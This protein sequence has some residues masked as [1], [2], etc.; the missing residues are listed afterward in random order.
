MALGKGDV[1]KVTHKSLKLLLE[2][3]CDIKIKNRTF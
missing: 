3:G 1:H 2:W